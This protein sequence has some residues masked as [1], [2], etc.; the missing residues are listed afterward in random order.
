[1]S[2]TQ[3]TDEARARFF[4]IKSGDNVRLSAMHS[5]P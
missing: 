3:S 1:V 2:F 4:V 5:A